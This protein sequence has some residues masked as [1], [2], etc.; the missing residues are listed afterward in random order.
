[1]DDAAKAAAAG[2]PDGH[3]VLADQQ[4]RGRGAHGRAWSSPAGTDLYFSIVARPA[5]EPSSTALITLAAGLGVRAAVQA[6]L[7]T[8]PVK[9][10]W[11][12]DIW[13]AGRKCAGILVESRMVGQSLDAVI[14]GV[15]LNVNRRR[16]PIELA[17]TATSLLEERGD[18]DPLDRSRVFADVLAEIEGFVSRLERDGA[19]VIVEELRPHL[20]LVGERVRWDDGEGVFEG[21]EADGAARVDT[22]AGTVSLRA[23]HLEPVSG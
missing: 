1:M 18:G 6:R 3:V 10:K 11:P 23:A 13:V 12:N 21:V 19:K 14:V 22:A 20:A 2:A 4:T 5:L 15:G 17:E 7:P 16:W 8:R 9:V